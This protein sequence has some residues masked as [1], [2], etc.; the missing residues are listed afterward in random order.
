MG[1]L[2][3]NLEIGGGNGTQ[4]GAKIEGRGWKIEFGA[5][6]RSFDAGLQAVRAFRSRK[7]EWVFAA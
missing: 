1:F 5:G 6:L 2:L 3:G 4:G 7:R